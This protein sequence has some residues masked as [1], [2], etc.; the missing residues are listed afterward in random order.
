MDIGAA[1]TALLIPLILAGY[2]YRDELT[3]LDLWF[4]KRLESLKNSKYLWRYFYKER[5]RVRAGEKFY[6]YKKVGEDAYALK[7]VFG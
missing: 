1:I 2:A 7:V 5:H 4:M 3:R 6:S